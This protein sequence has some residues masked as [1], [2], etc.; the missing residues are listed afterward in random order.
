MTAPALLA[1]VRPLLDAAAFALAEDARRDP[2]D[3]RR[4]R[5]LAKRCAE[6]VVELDDWFAHEPREAEEIIT[7]LDRPDGGVKFHARRA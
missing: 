3:R 1:K 6:I 5:G 2:E 7:Q 4:C